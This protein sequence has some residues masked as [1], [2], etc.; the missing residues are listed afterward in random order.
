MEQR[1]AVFLER[2]SFHM[3][4][5]Q[6]RGRPQSG[7]RA[8][9]RPASILLV[10]NEL[11]LQVAIRA[12]FLSQAQFRLAA[13]CAA[14]SEA[15]PV[16]ETMPLDI[17]LVSLRLADGSGLEVVR[18]VKLFQPLCEVL[19]MATANDKEDILLSMQ[20]GASGCLLKENLVLPYRVR[21]NP[22]VSSVAFS[23]V[24]AKA[25][26]TMAARERKTVEASELSPVQGD[27]LRCVAS[28]FSN[29]EIARN[30]FMSSYNVDY[31]LRCL[32]KRFLVRNRGQLIRVALT[33]F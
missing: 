13:V 16:I 30:L 5:F 2:G 15:L 10:E 26:A 20:A 24:L 6:R 21:N 32:R 7:G 29:K 31:H 33:L 4:V 14:K 23:Q 8:A 19:V 9:A 28:G 11:R 1:I 17:V 12:C 27:V 22:I 18:A 25:S 3:D